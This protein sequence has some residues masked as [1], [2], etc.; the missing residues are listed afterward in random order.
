M[1]TKKCQKVITKLLD[2]GDFNTRITIINRNHIK[3]SKYSWKS[4]YFRDSIG[5]KIIEDSNKYY[6]VTLFVVS[7]FAF[8]KKSI[9]SEKYC[10]GNVLISSIWP[11]IEKADGVKIVLQE[12]KNKSEP[13]SWINSPRTVYVIVKN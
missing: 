11:L 12:I 4:E 6:H 5:K 1:L 13:N 7:L 9:I 3:V 8:G 2:D 10:K